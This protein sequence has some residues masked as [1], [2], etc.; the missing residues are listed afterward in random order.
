MKRLL[1]VCLSLLVGTGCGLAD[2]GDEAV[3]DLELGAN[4]QRMELTA[5]PNNTGTRLS[6]QS[7]PDGV[8]T[9]NQAHIWQHL[10]GRDLVLDLYVENLGPDKK[11]W[12]VDEWNRKTTEVSYAR[13]YWNYDGAASW[14]FTTS[15]GKDNI[16]VRIKGLAF[17]DRPYSIF[18]NMSGQTYLNRITLEGGHAPRPP[19]RRA[20]RSPPTT[21]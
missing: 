7:T 16:L 13:D 1:G 11:I 21:P 2:D 18:V 5:F 4:E 17:T 9:I 20:H 3:V 6:T 15:D 14:R 19:S 8:V 12:V 10:Y